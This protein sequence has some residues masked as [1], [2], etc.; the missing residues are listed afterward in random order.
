MPPATVWR[1]VRVHLIR[2]SGRMYFRHLE[3]E[4][5][6]ECA[7]HL[8]QQTPDSRSHGFCDLAIWQISYQWLRRPQKPNCAVVRGRGRKDFSIPDAG[9]RF[10]PPDPVRRHSPTL[11]MQARVVLDYPRRPLAPIPIRASMPRVRRG[12]LSSIISAPAQCV[13]HSL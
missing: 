4:S 2:E 13:F 10:R 3:C 11:R 8:P 9:T 12:D 5:D 7:G 1:A 6:G